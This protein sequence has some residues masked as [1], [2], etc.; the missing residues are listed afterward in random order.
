MCNRLIC[1][2]KENKLQYDC[3]FGIQK[4]KSTY[5]AMV[6]IIDKIAEAS[7]WGECE[8]GVFLDFSNAFDTIEQKIILQKTKK[9]GIKEVPLKCFESYLS[10]RTQYVT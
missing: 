2:F 5:M 9:I 4:G 3:Q 7:G 10:E 6:A 1:F 8:V